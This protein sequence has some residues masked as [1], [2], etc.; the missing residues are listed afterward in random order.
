MSRPRLRL[1]RLSLSQAGSVQQLPFPFAN[2]ALD[3]EQ[4]LPIMV[5]RDPIVFQKPVCKLADYFH[6]VYLP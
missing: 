6:C 4:N 5:G 2:L 1:P 3:G